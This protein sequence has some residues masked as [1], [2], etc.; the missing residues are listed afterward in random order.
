VQRR[1]CQSMRCVGRETKEYIGCRFGGYLC[2]ET[3]VFPGASFSEYR[4]RIGRLSSEGFLA[5]E[6]MKPHPALLCF[7]WRG[8]S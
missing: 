8:Y 1:T 4:R 6:G 2:T 5:H 7:V 3:A